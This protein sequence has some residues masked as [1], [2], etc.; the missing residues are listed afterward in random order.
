MR[1][2][3]A[4]VVDMSSS[5]VH[6]PCPACGGRNRVQAERLTDQ[7]SCGRCKAALFPDHPAALDDAKFSSYVEHSDLPVVVDF[8]AT[9]CPPCRAMA[10]QFEAAAQE[11][12]G[13]VLFAKVDTD[14]AQLTSARFR[15]QSIP[16]LILL[17]GG[18]EVARQSGAV[19]Q[20]QI[21]TWLSTQLARSKAPKLTR[22]AEPA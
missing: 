5:S 15:I 10:P 3:A 21:Q 11:Q 8:W 19:S 22:D 13:R 20:Q 4:Y 1:A 18:R 12:R 2:S 9:W 17:R 6:I 7:P 14:N 16:T